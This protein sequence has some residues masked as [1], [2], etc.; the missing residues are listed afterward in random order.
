MQAIQRVF[1]KLNE[2]RGQSLL[3]IGICAPVILLF[4]LGLLDIIKYNIIY[5]D[6]SYFVKKEV[7][8]FASTPHAT[9]NQFAINLLSRISL[10]IWKR[11]ASSVTKLFLKTP[12]FQKTQT[13]YMSFRQKILVK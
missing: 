3:E 4:T 5:M 8:E 2:K 6:I 7:M 12:L 10:L 9:Y 1:H 11:K 13:R